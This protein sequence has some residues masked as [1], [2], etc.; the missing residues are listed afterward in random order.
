[1]DL[2]VIIKSYRVG[3]LH[4]F[5]ASLIHGV[6]DQSSSLRTIV[7]LGLRQTEED[8]AESLM[9]SSGQRTWRLEKFGKSLKDDQMPY[10]ARCKSGHN[11]GE[12]SDPARVSV[13]NGARLRQKQLGGGGPKDQGRALKRS[14]GSW[15]GRN[16]V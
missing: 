2:W 7:Q 13:G 15:I 16:H 5:S 9:F 4:S 3:P 11:V 6:I 14:R 8:E 1:M 12:S 10:L